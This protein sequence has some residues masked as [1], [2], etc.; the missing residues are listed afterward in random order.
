MV[1]TVVVTGLIGSVQSTRT[2]RHQ[3]AGRREEPAGLWE[4]E[5]R[6]D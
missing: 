1:V 2:Y 5:P 3:I 4:R 6:A